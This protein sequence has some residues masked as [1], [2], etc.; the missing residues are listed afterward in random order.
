MP[1]TCRDRS[2]QGGWLRIVQR[3]PPIDVYVLVFSTIIPQKTNK[4]GKKF[5]RIVRG[6]PARSWHRRQL[7]HPART[8]PKPTRGRGLREKQRA[9]KCGVLALCCFPF[10][11]VARGRATALAASVLCQMVCIRH[12]VAHDIQHMRRL[13]LPAKITWLASCLLSQTRLPHPYQVI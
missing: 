12:L 6:P 1:T 3:F 11:R 8:A 2:R 13:E 10:G 9:S 4:F 7:G 5:V